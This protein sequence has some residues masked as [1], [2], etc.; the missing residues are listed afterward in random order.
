MNNEEVPLPELVRAATEGDRESWDRLVVRF[1]P[2]VLSIS[3]RY[4]L[5]GHDAA[6][7]CQ[8]VWLRLLKHVGTLRVPAALPGWIVTTTRHECLRVLAANQRLNS[9]D[10]M[11]EPPTAASQSS[12]AWGEDFSEGLIRT[13]RHEALLIAFAEL[14]DRDRELLSL[15]VQDPPPSYAEI[16]ARLG[17]PVGSIGPTRARAI[18]RL[19]RNPALAA[20]RGSDHLEG[21]EGGAHDGTR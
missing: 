14:P 17:I 19:R 15:L 3:S 7:V 21:E 12:A 20:L 9:F 6:D 5:G 1:T 16:S 18:E 13:E 11:M 8:T 4:R 2:L 10:P